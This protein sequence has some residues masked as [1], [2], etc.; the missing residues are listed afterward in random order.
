MSNEYQQV[1]KGFSKMF[2]DYYF[3]GDIDEISINV[4]DMITSDFEDIK[5]T[6]NINEYLKYSPENGGD[7][8]YMDYVDETTTREDYILYIHLVDDITNYITTA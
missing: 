6:I 8:Y 7:E 1:I 4:E 2:W 3:Q 5:R